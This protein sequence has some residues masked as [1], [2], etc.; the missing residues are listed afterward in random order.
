LGDFEQHSFDAGVVRGIG[1]E[2]GPIQHCRQP[3]WHAGV[4]DGGTLKNIA[5]WHL[6]PVDQIDQRTPQWVE[7]QFNAV[8]FQFQSGRF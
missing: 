4:F 7:S 6:E 1:K 5:D 2:I 8:D 3:P